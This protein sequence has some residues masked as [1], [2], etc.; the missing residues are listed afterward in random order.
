[1]M[2][3]QRPP[4]HLPR[5]VLNTLISNLCHNLEIDHILVGQNFMSDEGYTF[6]NKM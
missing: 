3:K 4:T 5:D 6:T 1:M 2:D